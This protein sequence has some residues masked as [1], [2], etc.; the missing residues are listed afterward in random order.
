MKSLKLIFASFV[1]MLL[2][3]T[4]QP[5]YAQCA[6]CAANVETSHGGGNKQADGLNKGIIVLLAAPYLAVAVVG[7]IWFKRFRRR[8]VELNMRNERLNLN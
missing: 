4:T 1:L 5:I 6:M 2:F 3:S 8:N 7:Y